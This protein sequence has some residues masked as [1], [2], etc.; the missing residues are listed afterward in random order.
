MCTLLFLYYSLL[1]LRRLLIYKGHAR[2]DFYSIMIKLF[3]ITFS[4]M[5]NYPSKFLPLA[6]PAI[7]C[8]CY[9]WPTCHVNVLNVDG[10]FSTWLGWNYIRYQING[11]CQNSWGCYDVDLTI[12]LSHQCRKLNQ[13]QCSSP[14]NHRSVYIFLIK[15]CLLTIDLNVFNMFC[16]QCT[17]F[18]VFDLNKIKL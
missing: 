4:A 2:K 15:F 13:C 16:F 10:Y 3:V 9:I 18:G 7:N 14:L 1:Q 12:F 11:S 17:L 6:D 8:S 5:E